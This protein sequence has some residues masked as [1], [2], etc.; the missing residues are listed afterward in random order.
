FG[1]PPAGLWPSEGSISEAALEAM[2]RA[3]VRWAAS[4]EGVL[5]RSLGQ[6]LRRDEHGVVHPLDV[7][8]RPWV[9]R[10]AAGP[11]SLLFRDRALSDRIGFVYTNE[12]PEA[13]AA[14]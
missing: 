9:R 14:D 8:Y 7:L 6:A 3:G 10:T 4:D 2:A 13:S 12:E 5:E 1:R 11:V